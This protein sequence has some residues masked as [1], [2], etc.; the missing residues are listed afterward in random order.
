MKTCGVADAPVRCH[1]ACPWLWF[2][3]PS[4]GLQIPQYHVRFSTG[5]A[6]A[7]RL[8]RWPHMLLRAAASAVS[9]AMARQNGMRRITSNVALAAAVSQAPWPALAIIA[10]LK[11]A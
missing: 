8:R 10:M 5:H 2:L 3:W 4:P 11:L 1:P 7:R 9:V 6:V